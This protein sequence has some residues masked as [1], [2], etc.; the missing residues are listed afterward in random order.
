MTNQEHKNNWKAAHIVIGHIT[1]NG[2]YSMTS[3]LLNDYC[4]LSNASSVEEVKL[5]VLN[6]YM[7][8]NGSSVT[9]DYINA[10]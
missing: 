3:E 10:L 9:G 4:D 6:H 7:P 5:R 2:L 8:P 1:M